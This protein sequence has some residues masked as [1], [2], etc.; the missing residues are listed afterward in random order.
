MPNDGG[1]DGT[2]FEKRFPRGAAI[3]ADL[4]AA[5]R[6]ASRSPS[7]SGPRAAARRRS[8]AASPGWNA[9]SRARSASATR[10]GSTPTAGVFLAPQRRD[11]GFLFQDYALFPHLTVARN[12]ALRPPGHVGRR[13]PASRGRDASTASGSTAWRIATRSQVSGGQQQ[14]VALARVLVR[15]PRLLLLDE[16]L[17][18]LDAPLARAASPRTAAAARRVRQS[19]SCW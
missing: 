2:Q 14:R 13:A 5:G 4:P 19:P 15:R 16:P 9:P 12:I 11:I 17:S 1:A 6:R 8:C 3:R 10:R 7:C 18:A